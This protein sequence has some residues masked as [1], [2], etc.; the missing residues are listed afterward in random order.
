MAA[1]W[2]RD[3]SDGY[4]YF[5]EDP[6]RKMPGPVSVADSDLETRIRLPD[7]RP[8]GAHTSPIL[9]ARRAAEEQ[10]LCH[11]SRMVEV[12]KPLRRTPIYETH[13]KLGAKV[14]PFAGWEMP[15]WYTSV[16]E[17]HL[18]VRKAAGLFDVA[19]MGVYQAEGP[20]AAVFLDSVVGNDIGGL[21][22]GESCYTHLL[23]PD[24]EVIDD[25]LVYRRGS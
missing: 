21:E 10:S 24:A 8:G 19:H 4:V 2:L 1:A 15:V 3:L 13:K 22:V 7:R 20:D 18:A 16:V 23:T 11:L 25:L 5:D 6:L 9:S 14:I 12:E 17:E